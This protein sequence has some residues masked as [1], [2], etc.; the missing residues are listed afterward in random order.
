[1]HSQAQTMTWHLQK[2][3]NQEMLLKTG[4]KN[5]QTVGSPFYRSE[6]TVKLYAVILGETFNRKAFP[7]THP[8]VVFSASCVHSETISGGTTGAAT[9]HPSDLQVVGDGKKLHWEWETAEMPHPQ[10]PV[11]L[12]WLAGPRWEVRRWAL[13]LG[14][15]LLMYATYL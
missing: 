7:H 1:M 12:P 6:C 4:K 5:C 9:G 10:L 3:L 2:M 11:A 8:F 13:R 14:D 15:C